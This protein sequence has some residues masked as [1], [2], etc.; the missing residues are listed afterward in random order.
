MAFLEDLIRSGRIVDIAIAFLVLE[1][2]IVSI[3]RRSRQRSW[4]SRLKMIPCAPKRTSPRAIPASPRMSAPFF[5]T[6]ASETNSV[7]CAMRGTS[8]GRE[9]TPG[10]SCS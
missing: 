3:I 8:P 1:L 9:T 5:A 7:T 2:I 4:V 6:G 10:H